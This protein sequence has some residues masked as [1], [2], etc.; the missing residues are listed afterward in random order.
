[1]MTDSMTQF[2]PKDPINVENGRLALSNQLQ[3]MIKAFSEG[4]SVNELVVERTN[5][6]D[7]LLKRLWVELN[8]NQYEDLALIAVG[9][10]GRGDLQPYSDIDILFL[11][12]SPIDENLSNIISNFTSLVWDLKLE[13]GQSVRTIDECLDEGSK[14][15]TIATNLL[16]S[17]LII[18][19]EETYK[20]L[21]KIVE[22]ED[23]WPSDNFYNA[24]NDEQNDRH[25]SYKDTAFS[26]EPDIKNNPGGLRDIQTLLWISHKKFGTKTLKDM[27]GQNLLT[28]LEYIEIQ[29]C[30]DFLWR[31]RFAL[32]ISINRPDNRLTFD[33]QLKVAN[34]L[35]YEGNGNSAVESL[36]RRF[37]QTMQRVR[38]LNEI[39]M[40]LLEERIFPQRVKLGKIYNAYFIIRGSLIDVIDK[41][42]FIKRPQTILELFLILANETKITGIYV[43]C[44]RFLRNARRS[45]NY[46]L[47]EKE[48]CRKIFKE[49]ITN[50]RSLQVSLPLM[51]KHHIIALY[52]PHWQQILGLMQFDMFHTYTVDEHTMRVLKN[53]YAFTTQKQHN[54][55]LYRQIYS[56]IEKPELLFIAAIFHDI[57]KGRNGH[58]AEL[59]AP[60]A[61]HFC[62]LHGYNRYESRLVGWV[63][64][65]HLYMSM[66]AQR[67][68]I[69]DPEVVNEFAK[70]IGDETF[71]NYLYCLTV[72]DICATNDT[73]WNDYKDS[74]FRSLYFLTRDALRR[75][76]ENPPDLRLHVRENQQRALE[77]LI[78]IGIGPIEIFKVWGNFKLEYFIRYSAEQIAWHT[79]NIISHQGS[80]SPLI[81]FAQNQASQGTELFI[82]TKDMPCLFAKVTAVLCDKNLNVLSSLI[83]NTNNNY[84]LD[85]FTFMERNGTPVSFER[86]GT[87]RKGLTKALISDVYIPPKNKPLPLKLKQFKHPTVV[88]FLHDKDKKGT[89]LEISSLDVPGLLG[90]I[91]NVFQAHNLVTHAAKITTTGE[92]ADDFF[93]ITDASGTPLTEEKKEAFKKDLIDA[94]DND[95]SQ[96]KQSEITC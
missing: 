38:E 44:I 29:D 41:E 28:K 81:L 2:L 69:S 94:L 36:M 84:A 77:L 37:Y 62:Q 55:S 35:G 90:K 88:T 60:D 58:H 45:I 39:V 25:R 92:R 51:H 83:S 63:V 18:G 96:P 19:N 49:I 93:L 48:E 3:A 78:K 73:E 15:V 9:G 66:V 82:Y 16:E 43:E 68:D 50:P 67:R 71:L 52:M 40:Q 85:T 33:R 54:F 70:K 57:A 14:D 22:S 59:A 6:I 64:R 80:D 31:V 46:Y 23:F 95:P 87:I 89:S 10:Y 17:R 75:G 74:L 47:D 26:L 4:E 5:F 11:K 91:G 72:A 13:L 7:E 61:I 65:N 34:L 1:M 12:D 86:L 20:K 32:H 24:K 42:I 8:F 30:Q 76:L 79:Q 21:Y 53:I 56:Q 27:I